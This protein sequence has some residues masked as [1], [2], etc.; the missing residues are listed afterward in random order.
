[1]TSGTDDSR[2]AEPPAI[3]AADRPGAIE[4]VAVRHPGRWV[5]IAVLAVLLAMFVHLVV[6]NKEF[7]WDF[8]FQA[9]NQSPVIEGLVKGTLLVT[10]LSMVVGVGGGVVLAVMR[11]SDNPILSG[12]AWLFTWFFRSVPRYILLFTM[13]TLGILFQD[14]LSFGFPFDWKIIEWLGMSGDWRFLTLDANQVF[15]GVVAGVLGLGLSEAAYMAEIARAGIMSVDKGQ[16]EAAEALGMSR[17]KAMR[18]VVLPQAMRVIVPPTGNET[19]AMLKD[20]SLLI[21]VPVTT[22]L[23]YQ[24]QS[25]G[26]LYYKTFPVAVAA[27][28]YYLAATSV[29]MVGQYFLERHFGKGFGTK[30]PRAA[31]PAGAGG[32]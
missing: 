9:M 29:L 10:V 27:T 13:A 5:A 14:G 11:L 24:L 6:T 30:A 18:R 19:I 28:L 31:R 8:V 15:T 25:I 16:L 12:V 21:A 20:T 17:G 1:M 26:S 23:F 22:E 7:D 3:E 4:A 32:A 2:P